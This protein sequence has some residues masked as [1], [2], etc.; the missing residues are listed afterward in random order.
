MKGFTWLFFFAMV[1]CSKV[2]SLW[3]DERRPPEFCAVSLCGRI[4]AGGLTK[5]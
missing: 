1:A 4:R 5:F 3:P 2:G